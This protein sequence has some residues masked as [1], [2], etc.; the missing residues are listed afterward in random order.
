MRT[1]IILS[2]LVASLAGCATKHPYP[3]EA[4]PEATAEEKAAAFRE[5][6]RCVEAYTKILDDGVSQANLIAN[7]V[8]LSC[9]DAF[10][11]VYRTQLQGHTAAYAQGFDGG[12]WDKTRAQLVTRM[13][14][15]I[16]ARELA[17]KQRPE[18]QK[19]HSTEPR[20]SAVK[21]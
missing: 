9:R 17:A 13:V 10:A 7:E 5:A 11:P 8:S 6:G 2:I 21:N 19:N 14:L 16:R 18:T 20:P 1:V 15:A 3:L 12:D 4:M